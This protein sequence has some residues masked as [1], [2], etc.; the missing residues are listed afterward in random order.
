MHGLKLPY[1]GHWPPTAKSIQ[2]DSFLTSLSCTT[3]YLSI[4][5]VTYNIMRNILKMAEDA[6]YINKLFKRH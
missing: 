5:L 2:V 4:S 6:I 3:V 1:N